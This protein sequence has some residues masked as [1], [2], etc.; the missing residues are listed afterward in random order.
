MVFDTVGQNVNAGQPPA[1]TAPSA[2]T[3]AP[4]G[5]AP[6]YTNGAGLDGG[7]GLLNAAA[8]FMM[9]PFYMPFGKYVGRQYYTYQLFKVTDISDGKTT[10]I[11]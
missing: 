9:P 11:E 10:Q 1:T 2:A 6:M 8:P 4:L 5:T 3:T 7:A